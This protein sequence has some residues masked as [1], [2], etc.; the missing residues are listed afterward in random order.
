MNIKTEVEVVEK[1]LIADEIY[2]LLLKIEETPGYIPG[3]YVSLKVSEAGHRRS[4]SVASFKDGVI[5]LIVDVSPKGVGSVYVESLKVGDKVEIIAFLGNFVVETAETERAKRIYFVATGTGVAPLGPMI[6]KVLYGGFTG[7]VFLSWGL[8]HETG[9]YWL[10]YLESIKKKHS[11]FDFEIYLSKPTGEWKGKVG[12]VG[13][14]FME[15]ETYESVWYLCGAT[16][17][18]SQMKERLLARGVPEG[19]I[20][21]E[22][23]F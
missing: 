18:I 23:F 7:K 9:I 19:D 4:Y 22:K 2:Y 13:D 1:N 17:M 10:D 14:N 5:G 11:N 16:D 20:N 21:Y 15:M 12:H 8:R 3:Q 6:E